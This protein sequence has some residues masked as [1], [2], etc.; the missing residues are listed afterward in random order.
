MN[1]RPKLD[2]ETTQ[3]LIRSSWNEILGTATMRLVHDFN[4]LLTGILSLSDAY[5]VQTD[6]GNPAKEGFALMNQ[7]ARQGAAIVREISRLHQEQPGS[8]SYQDFAR[9]VPDSCEL[10]KKL[11]PRY[12]IIRTDFRTSSLP[13]YVDPV[14]FRRAFMS[15]AF[16]LVEA[17]APQG[18]LV[19][20]ADASAAD[21]SIELSAQIGSAQS[22]QV[23]SFFGKS[24]E[25][26]L[27]RA[28]VVRLV[29]EDFLTRNAGKLDA[30]LEENRAV[31][32]L[33]LPQSDFTELERDLAKKTA[34]AKST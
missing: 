19:V 5:L 20:M 16:M 2:Q 34:S 4:N 23:R 25:C 30:R 12:T 31:I 22:D 26:S 13:V 9:L 15:T 28:G 1:D 14:S 3:Y 33:S 7:N 10:L 8:P 18:E 11:L 27:D 6:D 29:I 17:S 21:C 32:L 24:T